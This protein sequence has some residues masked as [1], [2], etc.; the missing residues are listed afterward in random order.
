MSDLLVGWIVIHTAFWIPCQPIAWQAKQ[1]FSCFSALF[2]H[3][4]HYLPLRYLQFSCCLV[5][6]TAILCFPPPLSPGFYSGK[7]SRGSRYGNSAPMTINNVC[8]VVICV[9]LGVWQ[10]VVYGDSSDRKDDSLTDTHTHTFGVA[11]CCVEWVFMSRYTLACAQF[12][13][14]DCPKPWITLNPLHRFLKTE[15]LLLK[16]LYSGGGGRYSVSGNK[17]R[18]V[19]AFQFAL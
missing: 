7:F 1:T 18:N 2:E 4:F 3:S 12:S 5:S 13:C 6:S 16:D 9:L 11:L 14:L 15:F 8:L 19:A 17:I 10:M